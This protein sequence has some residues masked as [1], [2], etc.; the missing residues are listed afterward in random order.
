MTEQT[1]QTESPP[2]P[3]LDGLRVREGAMCGLTAEEILCELGRLDADAKSPALVQAIREGRMA[4]RAAIKRSLFAAATDGG[5]TA[6]REM[7]KLLEDPA[8][9]R[10]A[11]DW[12]VLERRVE[13]P[14]GTFRRFHLNRD[15]SMTPLPIDDEDRH[16]SNPREAAA[17][18]TRSAKWPAPADPLRI[19]PDI[20]NP[21]HYVPATLTMR[22][23]A[24][25][26]RSDLPDPE[27]TFWTHPH[28][29][30]PPASGPQSGSPSPAPPPGDL[31]PALRAPPPPG[32]RGPGGEVPGGGQGDGPERGER[33]PQGP[34]QRPATPPQ[35][36]VSRV[37]SIPGVMLDGP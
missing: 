1:T 2:T 10:S 17:I 29:G 35:G 20:R 8:P 36:P 34:A 5:V 19:E 21:W 16:G 25:E 12:V 14:D 31:S 22:A 27:S 4:G 32:G 18:R 11:N 13:Y 28:P 26:G 7:L 37:F 24:Y 30:K 23:V 3:P 33:S 6:Q 15:R 9:Q